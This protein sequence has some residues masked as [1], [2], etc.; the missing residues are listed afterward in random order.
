MMMISQMLKAT[1][2]KLLYACV[3]VCVSLF[4]WIHTYVLHI[5][6]LDL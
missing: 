5:H 4:L 2:V 3:C 6:E 1:R